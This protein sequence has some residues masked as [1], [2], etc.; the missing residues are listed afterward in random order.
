MT[1]N[2]QQEMDA[3]IESLEELDRAYYIDG[4]PLVS[5]LEYDRLYH[6]LQQLEQVYPKL[7]RPYSPTCRIG[8]DLSEELPE[9]S[10]KIPVLSLDKAYSASD[11]STWMHRTAAKAGGSLTFIVEEK[12]DG[13]SI[14]LYYEDGILM[15]AVTRGNG[16]IGNDVTGNV[17]T[18]SSVPL[19][20]REPVSLA[21]RG[22]LYLTVKEFE[23][24]ASGQDI[25]YAN[26][27]NLAAG[28][29][30]RVTSSAVARI[31]LRMFAYEGYILGSGS[32][33]ASHWAML[34]YLHALGFPV[35][36]RTALFYPQDMP[37]KAQEV[38]PG[39]V[40]GTFGDLEDYIRRI[41]AER[42]R[43][44]YEIDGLVV[45]VNELDVR[46]RLG[47]TG[48]HPRWAVAY[49]FEAPEAETDIK[50]ITVQVGRT[51]RITP[52]ARVK[53]VKIGGSVVS[54]VTLHNQD[55]IQMLEAA[56]GDT[57]AVSKRGDVIPAVERVIEK[58]AGSSP[59]WIMPERCPACSTE[60][61]KRGAHHFCPNDRCP[62]KISGSI[63][64]FI[65]RNQ[66]DID[67]FG[68]KTALLLISMGALTD[69][70]DIYRIDYDRMLSGQGGFGDKKIA[71]LKRGVETSRKR[72][73]KT[74]LASLGIPEVGEKAAE[75]LIEGGFTSIDALL[76][77][78]RKGDV[79]RLTSIKGIG[80]KLAEGITEALRDPVM[81]RRIR[82][83]QEAGLSFSTVQEGIRDDKQIFSG[84]TWC[85]TGSFI[86]FK[87]RSQAEE[88]IKR[89]GGKVTSAV[90][91]STT[92]LLSG[93]HPGS[94]LEKA[95]ALGIQVVSEE[96][97]LELIK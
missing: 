20:L 64:Y 80:E 45:K 55:Y 50:E 26:P 41:T 91:G 8:S 93:E 35:N 25:P 29:I 15:H 52:V 10:H 23:Q 17:K 82:M 84:E 19:R 77:A 36:S 58:G 78:S 38:P 70:A 40:V 65:G 88:E 31:P 48:H 81:L 60:L 47:F 96:E 61:V 49:K 97:F 14:V 59:Y 53:P 76:E 2:P 37:Q 30:R 3:L 66:M 21:V 46:D 63:L 22:E 89:R 69:P 12:I 51:G 13:V 83:L 56:P 68:P 6:R 32:T 27:R 95:K 24:I 94:K 4:K 54:N 73:Y 57:V 85:V 42:Q 74:V 75:M 9:V 90:S 86:N 92:R 79:E 1:E 5:D 7:K 16:Y 18:I 43:R 62:D 28:T 87:P 67:N 39:W 71:A 44:E 72:P 33:P 34:S 11:V